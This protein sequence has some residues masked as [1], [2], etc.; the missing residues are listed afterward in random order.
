MTN[1]DQHPFEKWLSTYASEEFDL[2][3]EQAINMVRMAWKQSDGALRERM[4]VAFVRSSEH[5]LAFFD[6]ARQNRVEFSTV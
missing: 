5:E 2:A 1:H 4:R 6:Q 3:T